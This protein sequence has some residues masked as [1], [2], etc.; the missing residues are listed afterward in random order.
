[1][2]RP[3]PPGKRL[4]GDV[5]VER[6]AASGSG[7]IDVIHCPNISPDWRYELEAGVMSDAAISQAMMLYSHGENKGYKRGIEAARRQMRGALGLSS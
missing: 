7:R 5:W 1:M 2:S 4:Y 6:N 3:D